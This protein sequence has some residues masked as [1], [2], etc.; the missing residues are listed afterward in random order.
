LTADTSLRFEVRYF[1][2]VTSAASESARFGTR[3]SFW[4]AGV[5]LSIRY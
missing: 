4:R 3:L 5:G 1:K 2:S